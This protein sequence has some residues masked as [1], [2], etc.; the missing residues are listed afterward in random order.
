MTYSNA[1]KFI[2]SAPTQLKESASRER[3]LSLWRLLELPKKNLKYLRLSG[4]CGKTVCTEL[5]SSLYADS[6]LSVGCLFMPLGGEFRENIRVGNRP[7]SFDE[8]VRHTDRVYR[9]V[10][11][12]NQ[13]RKETLLTEGGT[14]EE[15]DHSQP[16]SF[17]QH[18]LLL[19]VALLA[20]SEHGCKLCMIESDG[21]PSDPTRYLPS[22]Q[23][24]TL[25]GPI[26]ATDPQEI[27]Q[28]QA[29]ATHGIQELVCS[30]SGEKSYQ[31]MSNICSKINCRLTFASFKDVRIHSITPSSCVF[32]YRGMSYRTA[33]CGKFQIENL[34]LV[35][36]TMKALGRI[37]FPLPPEQ[38]Q[39]IIPSLKLPCRCEI[40]SLS[41]TMIIDSSH[42][43]SALSG[44]CD[45]LW[46]FRSA[47]G[48]KVHICAPEGVLPDMAADVFL[49]RGYE[50]CS[51]STLSEEAV[52]AYL[53][54]QK[55][56]GQLKQIEEFTKKMIATPADGE[57]LYVCG[58]P[59]FVAKLRHELLKQLGQ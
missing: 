9:A 53:P 45:S 44:V 8:L 38:L 55:R 19:T 52:T 4:V 16:L 28:I 34:I 6:S 47:T 13:S 1:I 40:L 24:L 5:L 33:L 30:I 20:F 2:H 41:P 39:A 12:L 21:S 59:T 50:V 10:K 11:L 51:V 46:E 14:V 31:L 17:T 7:L 23:I 48:T 26:D 58:S 42:H 49:K 25:C 57:I 37:G 29:Y 22:P 56:Y 36:E 32:D 54:L 35:L 3:L 18:E 27:R 15:V 43:P